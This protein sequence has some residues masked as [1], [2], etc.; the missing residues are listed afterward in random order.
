MLYLCIIKFDG[1]FDLINHNFP[2]ASAKVGGFFI[3]ISPFFVLLR[4]FFRPYLV[5]KCGNFPK[6]SANFLKNLVVFM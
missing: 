5:V 4:L 6:I 3:L 2:L 1:L